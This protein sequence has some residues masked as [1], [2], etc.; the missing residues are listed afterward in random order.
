MTYT[1]SPDGA[2]LKKIVNFGSGTD[3]TLYLGANVEIDPSG[4][5]SIHIH[6]D[7]KRVANATSSTLHYLHRDHLASVKVVLFVATAAWVSVL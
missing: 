4:T 1:Y 7:V 5:Y 3:T 2:R 6:S